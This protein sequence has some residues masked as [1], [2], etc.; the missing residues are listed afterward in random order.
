MLMSISERKNE[1]AMLKTLGYTNK[2]I[3]MQFS[4][5]GAFIG[6][7]G[8]IIG[9]ILGLI[10]SYYY[11]INGI[12]FSFFLQNSPSIG[13]RINGVVH[14]YIDYF[15]IFLIILGAI[16]VSLL[17]AFFAVRKTSKIEIIQ[18]FKQV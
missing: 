7:F 6:F 4:I 13:Y 16:L 3:Q 11:Q 8:T 10:I 17:S 5:E 18:L 2:Y 12:D 14:A 15:D 1:I 9:V